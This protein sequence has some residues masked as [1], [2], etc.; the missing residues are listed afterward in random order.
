MTKAHDDWLRKQV[1]QKVRWSLLMAGNRHRYGED[2][3]LAPAEIEAALWAV[4]DMPLEFITDRPLTDG[5]PSIEQTEQDAR[6]EAG[7]TA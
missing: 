2:G 4:E 5:L 7:M 6:R 1:V 3:R